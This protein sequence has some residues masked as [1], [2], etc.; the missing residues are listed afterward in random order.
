MRPRCVESGGHD[1]ALAQ[2]CRVFFNESNS[3][4]KIPVAMNAD[5]SS[6]DI[7]F[8]LRRRCA[9]PASSISCNRTPA[10]FEP[11]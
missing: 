3:H 2:R 7:F 9:S 1:K 10:T 5:Q 8:R 11:T 4:R 6:S